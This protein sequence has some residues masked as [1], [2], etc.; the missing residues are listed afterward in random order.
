MKMFED[1]EEVEEW[2]EPLG[3]DEFWREI[4][5]FNLEIQSKESCDEQ[6]AE[7]SVDEQTVLYVLKGLV[8]LQ[9]IEQHRLEPRDVMPWFNM[10]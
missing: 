8:R 7:G 6:I 9:I 3:Y 4:S 5:I 1:R 2:L 10:H